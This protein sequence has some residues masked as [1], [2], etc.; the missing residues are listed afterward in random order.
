MT[1]ATK[2]RTQ[3]QIDWKA[4]KQQLQAQAIAN[5][6]RFK[7]AHKRLQELKQQG[8]ELAS[9]G[10]YCHAMGDYSPNNTWLLYLQGAKPWR[11]VPYHSLFERVT[12]E[13]WGK[14]KRAKFQRDASKVYTVC[15]RQKGSKVTEDGEAEDY[16]YYGTG[17]VINVEDVNGW[18]EAPTGSPITE[19]DDLPF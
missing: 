15:N 11:F 7:A 5:K 1:T 4:K 18:S 16:T 14:Y 2:S 12:T 13:K 9:V 8:A 10:V 6:E 19:L 17:L 3:Q